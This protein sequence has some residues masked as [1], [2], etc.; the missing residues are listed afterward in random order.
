MINSF[1]LTCEVADYVK[2]SAEFMGKQMQTATGNNPAYSDEAPFL[3][4]MA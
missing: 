1:E 2:F 3:A 4:S